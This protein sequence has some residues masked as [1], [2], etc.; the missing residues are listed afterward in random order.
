MNISLEKVHFVGLCCINYKV[1][2]LTSVFHR[3][4]K[5]VEW[6]NLRIHVFFHCFYR[7]INLEWLIDWRTN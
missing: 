7:L 6:K 5:I 1:C 2:H 4:L 3:E